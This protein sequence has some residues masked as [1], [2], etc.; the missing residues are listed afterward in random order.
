[1]IRFFCKHISSITKIFILLQIP[2]HPSTIHV[3]SYTRV[4][5]CTQ[6]DFASFTASCCFLI[7]SPIPFLRFQFWFIFSKVILG[8]FL[9]EYKTD[10]ISE[11]LCFCKFFF[12]LFFLTDERCFGWVYISFRWYTF[13]F[14]SYLS[15]LFYCLQ[16]YSVVN[17]KSDNRLSYFYFCMK[18]CSFF[19]SFLGL[20]FENFS[21]ICLSNFFCN[22]AFW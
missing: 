10:I 16:A 7:K 11:S 18:T 13:S 14:S 17:E 9:T 2:S 6:Q 4:H 19:F 20:D 1:M 22:Q 15:N 8:V 12:F 3:D 21:K 5:T